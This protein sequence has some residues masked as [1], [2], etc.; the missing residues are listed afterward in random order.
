MTRAAGVATIAVLLA[1]SI[2]PGPGAPSRAA[3]GQ[4]E[5][6]SAGVVRVAYPEEPL[7]WHPAAARADLRFPLDHPAAVD[8]AA[9]W[10][11]PLYRID[12]WGQLRP[13]LAESA[14]VV[15]GEP[16]AV[17]VRLRPGSWS[18]G[19]PVVAQDVVATLHELRSRA[20]G[21]L[22]PLVGAE[23]VDDRTV[24][25]LFDRPYGRW[26]YLLAG[27]WSVLPAHVIGS[28]GIDRYAEEVPVSG[29]PF[30][31]ARHE[32]GL[33][34]VFTAH[35]GSPLGPPALDRIEVY[36]TPDYETSLGLLA[37][38]RVDVV[39]GYLG[40][41]AVDRAT[42]IDAVE[43]A[44]PLGGTW[45]SLLWRDV[46]RAVRQA[47]R[48]SV[49]VQELIEG[50]LGEAG[51]PMTSLIPGVDGPWSPAGGAGS[52]VA[53]D[54]RNLT[55]LLAGEQEALGFSA[56]VVQRE[57][58]AG[59]AD[60]EL[61]RVDPDELPRPADGAVVVRRDTPR[62]S[63]LVR[64]GDDVPPDVRGLLV[65][66]DRAG[67]PTAGTLAVAMDALHEV[68]VELPL[69]RV[70]VAHAWHRDL[71]GLAPSSWAGIGFWSVGEWSWPDGPPAQAP[72]LRR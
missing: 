43:A 25:L 70:A 26:P 5:D 48:E 46:D 57:L 3:A 30:A 7:Q 1:A 17:E 72:P 9:L 61:A 32:P 23:E 41:N 12:L 40:L 35:P 44:A 55:V 19:R 24:R 38:R 50:L 27:G 6:R 71:A 29:G 56:R 54:G 36:F 64:Y 52:A 65:A 4:T 58:E 16:W 68:A 2:L 51:A 59:G 47:A 62:P 63:L 53:L 11:L 28:G 20:D 37:E 14:R 10:G 45:V 22:D 49:E 42:D 39:L 33:R 31:L 18:D 60:V 15:P 69:Y 66:A 67:S 8:L 21:G 34:A 13:G